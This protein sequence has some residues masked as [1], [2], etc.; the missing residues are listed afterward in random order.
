MKNV[1]QRKNSSQSKRKS[2]K[3]AYW[4]KPDG[5]NQRIV[6][7]KVKGKK[8]EWAIKYTEDCLIPIKGGKF[9]VECMP[10]ATEAIHFTKDSKIKP[11]MLSY[12]QA[13]KIN[14]LEAFHARYRDI[15]K[16]KESALMYVI[17]LAIA[18]FGIIN[19]LVVTGHLRF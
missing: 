7:D 3:K 2:T 9:A 4:R 14:F 17:L 18:A 8:R 5:R 13:R 19:L 16:M 11:P 1:Q 10:Y 12:Q 6:I 15:G